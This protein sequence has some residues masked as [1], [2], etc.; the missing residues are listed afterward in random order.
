MSKQEQQISN[1]EIYDNLNALRQEL[2]SRDDLLEDKVDK[3]YLKIQVFEAEI[4]PLRK[5]V[6]GLIAI[7]GASLMTALMALLLKGA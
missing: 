2:T 7:A 1:K 6:Y 4:N 5:F 3:T